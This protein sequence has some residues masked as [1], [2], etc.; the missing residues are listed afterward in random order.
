MATPRSVRFDEAVA[1]R[2]RQFVARHPE[3]SASAA[4]NRLV[5][6]GLRMEEHPGVHFRSGPAGRRAVLIGGPDV[7][8]VVRAVRDARAAEPGLGADEVLELVTANTGA[9][10]S[11]V[12]AALA[13]WSDHPEEVD[14]AVQDADRA[15][16]ALLASQER[17][18]GLLSR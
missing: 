8:E 15:E 2:L 9:A 18:R 3:S 14:A 12:D 16:E 13:Y 10:R 6:E 17:R 4:V 1:G 11:M 5:D 7:W